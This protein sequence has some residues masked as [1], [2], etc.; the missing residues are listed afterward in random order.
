M[1]CMQRNEQVFYYAQYVD[2]TEV[3]DDY[4]N[5]TGTYTL[6]Y[7]TPIQSRGNISAARGE[8][9]TMQFGDNARYDRV[10]VI[11]DPKF[12]I[13]EQSILWIECNPQVAS[14]AATVKHDYIVNKVARSLNSVSIAV[15]KVNVS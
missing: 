14:G 1:R 8:S 7:G 15:S 10:I 2:K 11:C 5:A 4:G 9:S 13:D 12:P 3:L 6:N